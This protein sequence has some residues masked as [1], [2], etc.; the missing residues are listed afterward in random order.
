M[1]ENRY[2]DLGLSVKWG[3]CNIGA[4]KP[5]KFG[6][7][8]AWGE[9]ETMWNIL[10]GNY[11]FLLK[12][13]SW[14]YQELSKYNFKVK[15]PKSDT[16]KTGG[17][18]DNKETLEP[19][20]DAAHI[21]MGGSWRMPTKSEFQ[22]LI[23]K[24][25]CQWTTVNGVKGYTG[26]KK[27]YKD[28]SIFLPAG[29]YQS[30]N[31]RQDEGLNCYYWTSSLYPDGPTTAFYISADNSGINIYVTSRSYGFPIRPVCKKII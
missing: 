9:T 4:S 1:E 14:L 28:R 5:E 29:G 24:C 11:K 26:R 7:F 25:D 19:E 12:N 6:D 27:G 17:V 31:V 30:S 8:Y 23:N 3:T 18:Y 10:L 13:D 22:E 2:V 21:K 20:D 16:L 15:D